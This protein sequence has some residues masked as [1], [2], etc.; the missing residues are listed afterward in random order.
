MKLEDKLGWIAMKF[1]GDR[2]G[3][4]E[5]AVKEYAQVVF[6]LVESGVWHEIPSFEE[7]LPDKYMPEVFYTYWGLSIPNKN[8]EKI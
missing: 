4:R 1:R 7:M 2:P 3:E 8:S 6:E 5:E